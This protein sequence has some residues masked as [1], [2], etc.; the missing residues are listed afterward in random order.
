MSK[1]VVVVDAADIHAVTT[2]LHKALT[3]YGPAVVIRDPRAGRLL[4]ENEAV[5]QDV[6]EDTA[7]LI[8]T[9][10]SSGKPKT[11]ALSAQALKV[12]AQST[13]ERLGG[14]GQW[15]LSLPLTF[16]AGASVIVRS[17]VAGTTPIQVPSG[18][19]VPEVFLECVEKMSGENKYAALVP[20]QLA[21]L[22]E[23]VQTNKTQLEILKRLDAIL[24]GGQ[25]LDPVT[26]A[27]AYELGVN[28]VRTYGSSETAGGCVYDGI[29]LSGVEIELDPLTAE[30]LISAP[31]LATGY[32]GDHDRTK[33]VFQKRNGK[34]WYRSG[35]LGALTNGVLSVTGRVDRTIISG[36]LKINLDEVHKVISLNLGLT[37]AVVVHIP[38]LEWG[39]SPAVVL[40]TL[41]D[42]SLEEMTQLI[43]E[44]VVSQLGRAAAPALVMYVDVLPRLSSGK[45]DLVAIT[46][47]AAS[48]S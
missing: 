31:Q 36:G 21:R 9:S 37:D 11:V 47:L 42:K 45:P 10:G 33:D 40:E 6:P 8:S 22:L 23:A 41:E 7:L 46:A 43:T 15:L 44:E 35:D 25:S 3:Q 32:V 13:H 48:Q 20:I 39:A 1:G 2:A 18:P 14:S 26:K 16:I 34:T 29:A 12:A 38:N 4:T 19:F 30:I 27:K 5:L 17:L 24:I 28:I